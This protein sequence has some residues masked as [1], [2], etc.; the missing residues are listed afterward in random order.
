M[1]TK[2]NSSHQSQGSKPVLTQTENNTTLWIGHLQSDPTDHFAG[3]T[4]TCPSDGVLNN[5][6][7][8]SSAVSVPGDI[9][10]TLHEFDE[11]TRTWGRSIGNSALS[12]DRN[13]NGRWIRFELQPVPLNKNATY[14][15]RFHS[16]NAM[17]GLGEA[18]HHAKKPFSFGHAWNGTSK[19]ISG[20]FF[21]FF[22]LAFKVELC[23]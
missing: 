15:F 7:V 9:T 20:Y 6:Q 18:A 22:S 21:D 3:Q 8:Y 16:N 12:L 4:F 10:L 13:D 19:N 23:A 17:I 1:E 5:I 11:Q 2:R 14:G